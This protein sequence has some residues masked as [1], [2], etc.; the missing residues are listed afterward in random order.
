M[1]LHA[2]RPSRDIAARLRAAAEICAANGAQLTPLRRE[3]LEL[4]L[5]AEAPVTAYRLLDQLK[6]LRKSAVPPTIYRALEFLLENGLVHRIERLNAFVPCAEA[7]P[8]HDHGGAQFL[9]CQ[10][11]G[12]ASEVEDAA[13]SA[14]LAAAAARRGFLPSRAVVEV[15]G[16]CAVCADHTAKP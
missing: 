2:P 13:V 11:C 9:I 8:H 6:A 12:A 5:R 15:E 16:L 3:V 14:A 7:G 4:I 1:P 10:V